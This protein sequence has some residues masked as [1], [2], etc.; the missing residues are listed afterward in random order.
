[1]IIGFKGQEPPASSIVRKARN[2]EPSTPNPKPK[3][4]K[5]TNPKSEGINSTPHKPNALSLKAKA[6]AQH[7]GA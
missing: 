3:N 4:P 1:M 6:S 5:P 7:P 2:P